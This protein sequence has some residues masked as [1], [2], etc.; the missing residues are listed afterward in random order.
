[1]NRIGMLLPD[2]SMVIVSQPNDPVAGSRP[3]GLL[4]A[5]GWIAQIT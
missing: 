4:R 2:S 3:D 1:M 5:R